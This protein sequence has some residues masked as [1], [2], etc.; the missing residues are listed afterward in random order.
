MTV[1]GR[2]SKR[3]TRTH[4]GG[5]R[6]SRGSRGRRSTQKGGGGAADYMLKTFGSGDQQWNNTFKGD[7]NAGPISP[8][9]SVASGAKAPDLSL[10]QSAGSRRT[11]RRRGRSSK[12]GFFGS[13]LSTAAAPLALFGLNY[14]F[15]R[16]FKR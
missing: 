15:G 3:H 10:I 1:G 6:K 5:K 11:K 4:K 13:A 2:R 16:K 7:G 9:N 8:L 12:G 14:K